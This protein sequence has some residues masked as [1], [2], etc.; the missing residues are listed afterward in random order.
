MA[1]DG[2]REGGAPRVSAARLAAFA[3]LLRLEGGRARLDDSHAGLPELTGLEERDRSLANELVVGVVKRRLTLDAVADGFARAPLR[4]SPAAARVAVRLG[5]YQVLFLDRVPPYAAVAESVALASWRAPRSAGFVNAVL[6]RV[7]DEG[8]RRLAALTAGDDDRAW[9]LRWGLPVWMVR[10]LRRDL[11]DG[12][13]AGF[14][15]AALAAPERCLRVNRLRAEPAAAMAALAA[16]GGDVTPLPGLPDALVWDGPPLDRSQPVAA[17]LVVPQSRGSQVVGHVAAA[18]VLR[19]DAAVIDLCAAPGL[20]TAH[21][22]ALLPGARLTAVERDP[23]RAAALRET[24]SRLGA[25]DI[26]VVVG[27]ARDVA[28]ERP[29]AYDAALLDAPCSGLGALGTRPD[30]RH[31]RRP[32]DLAR[33]AAAQRELLAAAA[34][35]VR[36]GG[37]LTYAVCTVEREETLEVVASLLAGGGWACDDL[38]EAWPGMAHPAAGGCLLLLPPRHGSTGFFVA[39]LRRQ[40]SERPS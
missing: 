21:L 39:R 28:R 14:A 13:A 1:G 17:G 23:G 18:G 26:E 20:K 38:S 8:A 9:S 22:R 25:D 4:R 11:G 33:H 32:G 24:L 34:T 2:V 35:C 19:P 40:P 15:A 30:L 5:A 12:A 37:T 10:V 36:P 16:A 29:G 3:A 7:A 31:R 27:D 6:R